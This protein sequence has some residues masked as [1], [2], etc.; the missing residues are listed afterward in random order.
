[1]PKDRAKTAYVCR[2]CGASSL[3]WLGRC[4]DCGQWNTLQETVVRVTPSRAA[5][6]G[7]PAVSVTP[8]PLADVDGSS[9]PRMPLPL[10]EVDRVLGGGIVPGSL[11]LIGGDPG[12]G[13]STLL[14]QLAHAVAQRHGTVVYVSGEESTQQIKLRATRLGIATRPDDIDGKRLL[15]YPETDLEQVIAALDAA[16]PALAIIDSIQTMS[17]A[18]LPSAAGSVTQVRESCLRL[19]RWAKH[20]GVPVLIAGHVTKDGAIAGPRILEHMV[21]VVLYLEGE[22]FSPFRVLRGVKNRFGSTNEVGIFEMRDAGLVEVSNPSEAFLAHR[23]EAAIGSAIVPALEGTRPLLVEVQALTTPTSAPAP[24]RIANGVDG[25]RVLLLT[26]VMARHLGMRL[27][28][29]DILVNVVGGLRI[30]EP[31]ADA[32]IALAIASSFRNAPVRSGL[33]ALGEVGLSG[34]LRPVSQ[35][36]RRLA[37]AAALGFRRC[38]LPHAAIER[39]GKTK[40]MQLTGVATLAEAI[41]AALAPAG[42]SADPFPDAGQ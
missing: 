18:D 1:M 2:D 17:L 23:Q 30:S 34:E 14:L 5:A 39:A 3:R 11:T 15:L 6:H 12:I 22:G 21:D 32:A 38:I 13:K 25:N 28:N 31:A 33:V 27:G 8:T 36:E 37:E 4:P 29:A 35:V 40:G 19:M 26:A 24:R 42:P 20:T 7:M 9:A 41:A 16:K 10:R